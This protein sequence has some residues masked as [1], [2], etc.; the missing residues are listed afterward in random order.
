MADMGKHLAVYF[1]ASY[2]V[3]AFFLFVVSLLKGAVF[4]ESTD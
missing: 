4:N 3:I 2:P 1:I